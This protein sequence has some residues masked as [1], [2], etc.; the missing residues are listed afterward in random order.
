MIILK[1]IGITLLVVLALVLCVILAVLL[2]PFRYQIQGRHEKGGTTAAQISVR[3]FFRAVQIRLSYRHAL[4]L[5]LKL[6]G[7][8]VINKGMGEEQ[9]QAVIRD[10]VP[11]ADLR[12]ERNGQR[13]KP[14]EASEKAIHHPVPP[15][16]KE[17][18]LPDSADVELPDRTTADAEADNADSVTG[19]SG[20]S[21]KPQ[22]LSPE[23]QNL[24]LPPEGFSPG[25]GT[26]E[27]RPMPER[28]LEKEITGNFFQ[29][30]EERLWQALL[31][32]VRKL[33][34]F[35][36]KMKNKVT[37]FSN[38]VE[39]KREKL[40]AL[41]DKYYT[42]ENVALLRTVYRRGEKIILHIAPKN[43]MIKID[44]GMDDPALT[45]QILA[46]S[47]FIGYRS[48]QLDITPYFEEERL[49]VLADIDGRIRLGTVAYHALR[50]VLN[51]N[52]RK[53]I[54]DIKGR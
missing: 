45:G 3:W 43:A 42:E 44:I 50:I 1:I 35:I 12:F 51:G 38:K 7:R 6:F 9:L 25:E 26:T 19:E 52:C 30:M 48:V 20:R 40:D 24:Y 10:E 21:V 33:R 16:P 13:K 37:D 18:V 31:R 8:T 14:S 47:S 11:V 4:R 49:R 17:P 39:E 29:R 5:R 53:L 34:M 22:R 15:E 28:P 46:L 32:Q 23:I 36:L 27:G 41:T 2:I 54:R